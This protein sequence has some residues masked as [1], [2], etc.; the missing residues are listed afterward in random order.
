MLHQR[1]RIELVEPLQDW[2]QNSLQSITCLL[3][4]HSI[5]IQSALLDFH[6]RD[7]ADRF[8]ISISLVYDC[9]LM[10]F[11]NKFTLYPEL[12]NRLIGRSLV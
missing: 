7:P 6:H 4:N 11:D 3:L 2:F 5:A 1:N 12:K 9:Q 8:I 10:S